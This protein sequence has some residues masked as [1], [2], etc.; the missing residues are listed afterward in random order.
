MFWQRLRSLIR[1]EFIQIRRDPRTLALTFLL[2]FVQLV[3]LGYAATNDVRNVPLVVFDQ[4]K[5]AASRELIEAY[6][7]ADYFALRYD[8][9]S[10]GELQQLIE[11]NNAQAAMIIPPD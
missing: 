10:E 2:P 4:D 7:A 3:L 9:Q 6:R 11:A 8:V 5:S 1:K